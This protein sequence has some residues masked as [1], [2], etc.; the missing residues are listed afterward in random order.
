MSLSAHATATR[1]RAGGA[2]VIAFPVVLAA[3]D[4][5][6]PSF[7]HGTQLVIAVAAHPARTWALAGLRLAAAALFLAAVA[8]VAAQ[9]RGR[10]SRV[11]ITAVVLG[12]LGALGQAQDAAYQ[13]FVLNLRHEDP[14][15]AGALLTRLDSLAAP[16]ELP[17][18]LAFAVALV[19]VVVAAW[20]GG[21]AP[22]WALAAACGAFLAHLAPGVGASRVAD[23]LLGVAYLW[24]GWRLLN[25][26]TDTT[27]PTD[28]DRP[29]AAP[30]AAWPRQLAPGP[31]P[32]LP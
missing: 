16:L 14:Q 15:A 13:L 25:A 22:T 24:L 8:S 10:G 32:R 6:A 27:A 17:L 5:V 11:A 2:A 4:L 3:S 20:R 29:A 12:T 23:L 1:R 21:I 31:R 18:L 19:L 7:D 26:R 30:S 9:V 28:S